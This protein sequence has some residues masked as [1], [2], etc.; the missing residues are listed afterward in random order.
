MDWASVMTSDVCHRES[1]SADWKGFPMM[2]RKSDAAGGWLL[3]GTRPSETNRW[4]SSATPPKAFSDAAT[5]ASHSAAHLTRSSEESDDIPWRTARTLCLARLSAAL[6]GTI[7][8]GDHQCLPAR[9]AAA[10]GHVGY[11]GRRAVR[12]PRRVSTDQDQRLRHRDRRAVS[13]DRGDDGQVRP[14]SARSS[15]A[16]G[17]II[18]SM[19]HRPARSK[20]SL[21]AVGPRWALGSKLQGPVNQRSRRI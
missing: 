18:P 3:G 20:T 7:A 12:N 11:Q 9:R 8:Q 17:R 1:M 2:Q 4:I 21:P 10:S 19:H 13:Q 15:G 6:G 14:S 16:T 5:S